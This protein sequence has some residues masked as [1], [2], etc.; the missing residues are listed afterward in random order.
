MKRKVQ[1]STT[2]PRPLIAPQTS[3]RSAHSTSS[4]SHSVLSCPSARYGTYHE[5]NFPWPRRPL[6]SSSPSP[7]PQPTTHHQPYSCPYTP[8]AAPTR[9]ILHRRPASCGAPYPQAQHQ[10]CCCTSR[11]PSC[12]RIAPTWWAAWVLGAACVE[13]ESLRVVGEKGGRPVARR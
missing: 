2:S 11:C 9:P 3:L 5:S 10:A 6:P 1:L 12:A 7:S 4:S 13:G 8:S